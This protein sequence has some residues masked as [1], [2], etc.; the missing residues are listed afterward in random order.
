MARYQ[1]ARTGAVRRG[2]IRNVLTG[3]AQASSSSGGGGGGGGGLTPPVA[4]ADLETIAALSVLGNPTNATDLIQAIQAMSDGQVLRRSGS[5]VGFG[6]VD[7]GNANARTG[8]LPWANLEDV[9]ATARLL[10]RKT[11]GSGAIE[12]LTLTDALDLG[13]AAAQGDILYRAASAWA[14]LAPGAAGQILSTQGTGADPQWIGRVDPS[15]FE[16]AVATATYD[17]AQLDVMSTT[18]QVLV[19]AVPGKIIV[20][21]QLVAITQNATPAWNSGNSVQLRYS[22]D[23]VNLLSCQALNSVAGATLV[24]YNGGPPATGFFTDSAIRGVDVMAKMA[25]NPTPS[26]G[27]GGD[28]TLFVWY[29]LI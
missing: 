23:T 19:P 9:S 15:L 10:G 1:R 16:I 8:K 20:P 17:T 3:V 18:L 22:G 11:S 25:N 12:E 2:H 4:L 5:A 24:A 13:G 29:T 6:A 7:L 21:F 14:L 28:L 27:G 26:V